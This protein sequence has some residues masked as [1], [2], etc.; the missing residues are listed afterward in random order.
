MTFSRV[1]FVIICLILIAYILEKKFLPEDVRN[2]I[3]L[4]PFNW[5]A[6]TQVAPTTTLA[7]NNSD[8][9][10]KEF[11]EFADQVF[12]RLPQKEELKNS[13]GS[14][15]HQMPK[16]M[17]EAAAKLGQIRAMIEAQ[18][19]LK[20]EALIHYQSC[21][22]KKELAT[23]IRAVCFNDAK[24]LHVELFNSPWDYDKQ[25]IGAEVI[26]LAEKIGAYQ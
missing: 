20:K 24:Q 2:S 11:K 18:P 14:A 12:D 10:L 17:M 9:T 23:S 5:S 7:T 19:Q 16:P 1:A 13:K 4:P 15:V 6:T 26:T 25:M 22:K 21:A 3:P 8:Q